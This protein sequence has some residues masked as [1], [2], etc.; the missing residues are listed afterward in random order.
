MSIL[1]RWILILNGVDLGNLSLKSVIL[2]RELFIFWL[3]LAI[4]L[5][6]LN[7]SILYS[8]LGILW[9]IY[10]LIFIL[11]RRCNCIIFR[12]CLVAIN[13]SAIDNRWTS[14]ILWR[15]KNRHIGI[16]WFRKSSRNFASNDRFELHFYSICLCVLVIAISKK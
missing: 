9:R 8:G 14:N 6:V 13:Y 4:Q 11:C 7:F 5:L 15:R 2:R 16:K 10:G 1:R 3:A 12:G